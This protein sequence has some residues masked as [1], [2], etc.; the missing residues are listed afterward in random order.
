MVVIATDD[1]VLVIPKSQ[2]QK[3]KKIVEALK[4]A[5]KKEFL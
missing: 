2:S 4:E 5:G 3:V 1:A